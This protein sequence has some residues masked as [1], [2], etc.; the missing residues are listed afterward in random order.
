MCLSPITSA[1][2]DKRIR[3]AY[4][5]R[6]ASLE[7]FAKGLIN[8]SWIA[9]LEEGGQERRYLLQ[10]INRHVFHRPEHVVENMQRITRHL[11]A[12]I[13]RDGAGDTSRSVQSLVPTREGRPAHRDAPP[14]QRDR[15]VLMPM[16]HRG[17][18]RVVAALRPRQRDHIGIHHRV[19]DL[20]PGPDREGQ[21]KRIDLAEHAID[22]MRQMSR[23]M[24]FG[25]RPS[26]HGIYLV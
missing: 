1:V 14:S 22:T 2:S 25:R 26:L 16:A 3:D 21:Q 6:L 8:H 10:Q 24:I 4:K 15:P 23:R 12:Q 7:P 17:P 13:T 5:R 20:H 9:V 11:A 19:H 18:I